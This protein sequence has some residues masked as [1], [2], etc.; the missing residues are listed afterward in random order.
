MILKEA[1]GLAQ[2]C[3]DFK[4][5]REFT[6]RDPPSPSSEKQYILCIL[7]IGIN[8]KCSFPFQIGGV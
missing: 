1:E 8:K 2:V 7:S 4:W 6:N 3:E 5:M